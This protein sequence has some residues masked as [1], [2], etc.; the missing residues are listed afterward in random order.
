MVAMQDN[1]HTTLCESRLP[2]EKFR[3]WWLNGRLLALSTH[4]MKPSNGLHTILREGLFV[5]LS[6]HGFLVSLESATMTSDYASYL[7]HTVW[8]E[9]VVMEDKLNEE[10]RNRGSHVLICTPPVGLPES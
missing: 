5:L 8:I 7:L 4:A 1:V 9:F 6:V 10:A 2:Y 3:C